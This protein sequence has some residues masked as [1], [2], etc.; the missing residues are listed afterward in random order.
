MPTTPALRYGS[1]RVETERLDPE[2]RR[3]VR[4]EPVI[5]LVLFPDSARGKLRAV[6]LT[7]DQALDLIG[8]VSDALIRV[9]KI[10]RDRITRDRGP[11][12]PVVGEGKGKP[13]PT[14]APTS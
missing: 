1:V 7:E 10:T 8:R 12:S 2:T 5:E 13:E 14:T 11:L 9:R 6:P 3:Q 4:I